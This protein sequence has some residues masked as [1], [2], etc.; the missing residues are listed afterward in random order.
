MPSSSYERDLPPNWWR[1]EE[2]AAAFLEIFERAVADGSLTGLGW[3]V[4]EA[5]VLGQIGAD[6]AARSIAVASAVYWLRN[7]GPGVAAQ[8][9]A[10]E[11]G[12]LDSVAELLAGSFVADELSVPVSASIADVYRR[13][14]TSKP[15]PTGTSDLAEARKLSGRTLAKASISKA[16]VPH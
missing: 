1:D 4:E 5:E 14:G 10:E 16:S 9:S 15:P 7:V 12:A 11:P 13:L 3:V 8:L 2:G 6:G